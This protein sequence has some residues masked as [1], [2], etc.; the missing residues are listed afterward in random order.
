MSWRAAARWLLAALPLAAAAEDANEAARLAIRTKQFSQAVGLLAP[1]ARG[2][3]ADADYLLGL[4]HWNGVGTPADRDAARASLRRAAERGHGAAAFALAALLADGT[5]GERTEASGWI[6]RAAA[7]GYSP[8]IELRAARTLPLVDPRGAPGL[9]ADLRFAIAR[10]AA[11]ANDAALLALVVTRES[12]A[13]RGEFGRTLLFDAAAAGA[14]DAVRVLLGAGAVPEAADE[15]GQTPLMLAAVQS[16]VLVTRLL[17]DSGARA[18][19]ADK[20]GRTAL[21]RAAAADQA[22]QASALLAAGAGADLKDIDGWSAVDLAQRAGAAAALAVLHAAGGRPAVPAV[23][24]R[25]GGGVDATRPGALYQGWDPL[26]IAVAHDAAAEIRTRVAAGASVEATTPQGD[27]ALELAIDLRMAAAARALV[28]LGANLGRK[29]RDGSD[30]VERVVRSGDT[31]LFTEAVRPR[32]RLDSGAR[33]G[34]LLAIAVGRGDAAMMRALLAAGLPAT[35]ADG[36]RMTPLMHAARAGNADLAKLLLD[37]GARVADADVRGRT[38]LWYG[39]AAGS[40]PATAVL[41][42]VH[43][44]L[45]TADRDGV[46]PL[47]AAI[48]A[49][50]DDV[51]ARLLAAGAPAEAR[52]AGADAP[53]RFAAEAGHLRILTRLL[54]RRVQVDATDEFGET[55][56]MVAARN[57]DVQ[58]SVRL[59]S[60]GANAR[61][62]NR[63]RATAA[64][65]AEARGFMA[66]ADRLRD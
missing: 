41:L 18:N 43:A 49:G 11:H 29:G 58:I 65:L 14:A 40:A 17:L 27:S 51:V 20:A 30:P 63:E 66:L 12:A 7:A 61:L 3:S 26:L 13:R 64:D 36:D 54:E 60:A 53:L 21:F 24:V 42:A 22:G 52:S 44:P 6:E 8:A 25:S 56:L 46:T 59:L 47:L 48:R 31:A 32:V 4:A 45:D 9:G 33:A 35:A 15:Y 23:A 5:P 37:R 57:G 62:R 39:A 1:A 10:S 2:G 38:A 34:R 16:N 19:A 55:A 28:E 50:A